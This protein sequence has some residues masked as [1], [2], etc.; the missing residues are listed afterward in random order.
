MATSRTSCSI[1]VASLSL[2]ES[3][4]VLRQHSAPAREARA[5]IHGLQSAMSSVPAPSADVELVV[6]V[7]GTLALTEADRRLAGS[8]HI[9]AQAPRRQLLSYC[10]G[11]FSGYQ[12][13]SVLATLVHVG[14]AVVV[15][16]CSRSVALARW[17]W[18][19]FAVQALS[20]RLCLR[21]ML[22]CSIKTAAWR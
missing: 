21:P 22:V 6:K 14:A 8:Y 16:S 4:P 17:W 7:D 10:D 2:G 13:L 20:A 18:L 5:A 15:A 1:P 9:S 19:R 11:N 12:S 3:S